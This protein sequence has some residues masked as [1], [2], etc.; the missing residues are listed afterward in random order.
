MARLKEL[1]DCLGY[2]FQDMNLLRRALTHRSFSNENA[3]LCLPH[4]ESLEFLGD[5][6]MG[7]VISDRL[8]RLFPGSSEGEL[9]RFRSYL[10]SGDHLVHLAK[11]LNLGNFLLLSRGETKTKGSEKKNIL[12]DAFEAVV[13]AIFLDGGIEPVRTFIDRIFSEALTR[14]AQ[15]EVS[16]EDYKTV[17]QERLAEG[18]HLPPRYVTVAEE[19][20][21]HD[22]TFHVQV[23]SGDSVL[24]LGEGRTKKQAQQ[25][26][27][28]AA[29]EAIKDYVPPPPP[30]LP[31]QR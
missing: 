5:S 20:P 9:S 22:K 8:F 19:G 3:S 28:R 30:P 14:L 25:M 15:P 11:E 13:A 27:A 17:L 6:V 2:R 31:P 1:E 16:L 29:L 4:N 21:D 18:G 24:G 23:E 7:F 12:T 26:A 10:V